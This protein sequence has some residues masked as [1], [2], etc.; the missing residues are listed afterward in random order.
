MYAV[1]VQAKVKNGT[2]EIPEQYRGQI[3]EHVREILLI[4]EE[5][6]RADLIA[7]LLKHPVNVPGFTPLTRE[8]MYE[9]D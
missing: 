9:R 1:E 8:E 2:I 3:R 6:P 4:E 5:R 7:Q